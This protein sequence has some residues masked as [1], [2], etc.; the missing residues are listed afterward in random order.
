MH[1]VGFNRPFA[2]FDDPAGSSLESVVALAP[3]EAPRQVIGAR[4]SE[5]RAMAI[6]NLNGLIAI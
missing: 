6:D 5:K 3:Y 2:V 1:P 4:K